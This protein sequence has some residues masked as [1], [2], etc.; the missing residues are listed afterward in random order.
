MRTT[1]WTCL[2]RSSRATTLRPDHHRFGH[3]PCHDHGL[4]PVASVAASADRD[5]ACGVGSAVD[6]GTDDLR[7]APARGVRDA[8]LGRRRRH[9]HDGSRSALPAHPDRP[10]RRLRHRPCRAADL[11]RGRRPLA[12]G[13]GR[14]GTAGFARHGLSA[15]HLLRRSST[16]RALYCAPVRSRS[17][18]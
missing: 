7:R 4:R 2:P 16:R 10:S 15:G 17:G 6:R 13:V 8:L 9:R 11:D 1:I 18:S 5:A 14:L 3:R 12:F